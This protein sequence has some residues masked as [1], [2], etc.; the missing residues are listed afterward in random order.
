METVTD[1]QAIDP[2]DQ[3]VDVQVQTE[4]RRSTR[5]KKPAISSDFLCYLQETDYNI[6]DIDDPVT[7]QML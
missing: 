6:G 2:I 5:T 3:Q 4:I 7:T 1:L